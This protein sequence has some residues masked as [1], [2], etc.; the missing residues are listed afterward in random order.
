LVVCGHENGSRHFVGADCAHHLD[1][2]FPRHLYVEKN[3]IRLQ[4][5]DHVDRDIAV[6]RRPDHLHVT[7]MREEVD[8]ALP[9]QRFV[10]YHQHAQHL[11]R[12]VTHAGTSPSGTPAMRKSSAV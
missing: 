3:K 5:T 10:V 6:L 7:F 12:R 8:H 2:G 4:L 9:R 1:A 11:L